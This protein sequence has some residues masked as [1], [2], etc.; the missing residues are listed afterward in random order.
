MSSKVDPPIFTR[1]DCEG[2]G[3]T[4]L[5]QST[6]SASPDGSGELRSEENTD[7]HLTVSAQLHLEALALGMGRTN[8]MLGSRVHE[9]ELAVR[10]GDELS[11]VAAST[12]ETGQECNF[13]TFK[14][15]AQAGNKTSRELIKSWS[16]DGNSINRCIDF[17]PAHRALHSQ[18][19]TCMSDH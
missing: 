6:L 2:A 8:G 14:I 10:R 9:N 3:E 7:V 11:Q 16:T 4:F 5:I 17:V 19:Q 15:I 12:Y 18:L 1:T 13:A